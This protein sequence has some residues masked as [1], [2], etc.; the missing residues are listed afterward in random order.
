MLALRAGYRFRRSDVSGADGIT[1][2]LGLAY[3]RGLDYVL[4]YAFAGQGDLGA[5][6]RVSLTLRY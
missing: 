3:S 5:S 4:D 6:H 1:A 2:G